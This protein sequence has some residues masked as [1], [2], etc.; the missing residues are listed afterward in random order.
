MRGYDVAPGRV[1]EHA[2]RG[3]V[4]AD[5]PADAARGADT[6]L[7][8]LMTADIV[9]EALLGTGWRSRKARWA[10]RRA[11][12]SWPPRCTAGC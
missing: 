7:T 5:S 11:R 12:R 3:G 4:P 10:T 8:C 9:R 6:V 1:R 2:A